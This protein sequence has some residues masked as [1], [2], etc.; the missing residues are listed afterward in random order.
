MSGVDIKWLAEK[1]RM[2]RQVKQVAPSSAW[3]S[4][5]P[6]RPGRFW[7]TNDP[8][9]LTYF[10]YEIVESLNG[11]LGHWRPDDRIFYRVED[12]HRGGVWQ[13]VQ[14]PLP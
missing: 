7:W 5:P 13:P 6:R 8:T 4:E 1:I 10:F 9:R 12:L 2:V 3:S 14:E 11:V